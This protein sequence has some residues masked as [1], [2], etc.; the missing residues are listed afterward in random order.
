M[1]FEHVRRAGGPIITHIGLAVDNLDDRAKQMR[2]AGVDFTQVA[3][4]PSPH[5]GY[6]VIDIAPEGSC[7]MRDQNDRWKLSKMFPESHFGIRLQ[8]CEDI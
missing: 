5:G 8:L 7:G 4:T 2:K 1:D 3:V 6:K